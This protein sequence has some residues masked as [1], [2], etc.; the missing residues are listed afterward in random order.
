MSNGYIYCLSN[1]AMPGLVKIGEMHTEGRTPDDR[2]RE[3]YTT[4]VPLPF[5]IEFAKKVANPAEAEARIH[6]FISDKRVNPRRE[7]FKVTPDYIR[8]LFDLIDGEMWVRPD[9]EEKEE[10]DDNDPVPGKESTMQR[11]FVNGM[12]I[13]HVISQDPNKTWIG[14]YNVA[15]DKIIH[16]EISY[17]SPSNFGLMHNRVYY[18]DRQSTGGWVECECEVDG[19]WVNAASLKVKA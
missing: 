15:T 11:S 7:F 4:G 16:N 9:K 10:S 14:K 6:A 5:T 17:T 3:L 12:R 18:P 19:I 2:I 13:R 1:D 8:R